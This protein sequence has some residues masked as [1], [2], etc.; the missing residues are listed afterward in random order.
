[1]APKCT[2]VNAKVH[3]SV[4]KVGG[5]EF[6]C[7]GLT[8]SWD[9]WFEIK[10]LEALLIVPP[11]LTEC[12]FCKLFGHHFGSKGRRSPSAVVCSSSEFSFD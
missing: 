1:M 4:Y 9:V 2:L 12:D 6:S 5:E 3:L 8:G 10:R 11:A 7:V